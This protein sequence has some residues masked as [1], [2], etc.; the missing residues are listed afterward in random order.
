MGME[1]AKIEEIIEKEADKTY[2]DI[3]AKCKTYGEL[4]RAISTRLKEANWNNNAIGKILLE[5][6]MKRCEEEVEKIKML[7]EKGSEN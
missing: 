5:K 2:R 7:P 4:R 1:I 6:V 3:K